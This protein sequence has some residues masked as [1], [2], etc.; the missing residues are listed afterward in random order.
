[1]VSPEG[2]TNRP[3]DPTRRD[4][5]S[6]QIAGPCRTLGRS[7]FSL[8]E[9]LMVLA[10]MG[11]A[12]AIAAP[13]Y[14][15][16][17][18]RWRVRGAA[19]RLA[20][21]IE[22]ARA[23]AIATSSSVRISFSTSGYRFKASGDAAE[24]VRVDLTG[25]PY[26]ASIVSADINGSQILDL[27]GAGVGTSD[28]VVVVGAGLYRTAV[29]FSRARGTATVGE[30]YLSTRLTDPLLVEDDIEIDDDGPRVLEGGR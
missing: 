19:Q 18:T 27:N 14:A 23:T 25:R 8:A 29:S 28:G 6:G 3:L 11:V 13:R 12:A 16:A 7:A 15:E 30:A 20:A 17:E 9:L 5:A 2:N 21:D 10:I 24:E 4:L 1:M 26:M 22:R